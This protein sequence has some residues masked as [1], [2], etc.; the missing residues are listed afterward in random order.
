MKKESQTC[1]FFLKNLVFEKKICV[2]ASKNLEK[3]N[4]EDDHL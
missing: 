1:I 2:G 4:R 3:M